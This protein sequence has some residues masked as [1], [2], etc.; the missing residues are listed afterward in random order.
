MISADPADGKMKVVLG[1]MLATFTYQGTPVGKA[2]I[3]AS[4]ALKIVPVNNGYG[5]AVELD[6]PE[7]HVT[8]I[9]DIANATRLED[10]DLAKSVEVCLS[11]QIASI[12]KLLAGIPLPQ[13]AGLQMRNLSVGADDG[14]VMVKGDLE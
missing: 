7:I 9:D 2:A 4:I 12:S 3:N 8:T 14:Y 5:V 6:K 1:D 10:E 11:A 13:V